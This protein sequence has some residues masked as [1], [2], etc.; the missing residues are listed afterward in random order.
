VSIR[1]LPPAPPPGTAPT[2]TN[3]RPL[4]LLLAEDRPGREDGQG[5]RGVGGAGPGDVRHEGRS[6]PERLG[7]RR[8]SASRLAPAALGTA[9]PIAGCA[10]PERVHPTGSA[11]GKGRAR[12]GDAAPRVGGGD[13]I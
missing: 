3:G 13:G 8:R 12:R 2:A 4:P 11:D 5:G 9:A 10:G 7:E 1:T 6:G